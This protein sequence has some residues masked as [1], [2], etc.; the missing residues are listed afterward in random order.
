MASVLLSK[1]LL[2][3]D[4]KHLASKHHGGHPARYTTSAD[5]DAAVHDFTGFGHLGAF[6]CNDSCCRHLGG[7]GMFHGFCGLSFAYL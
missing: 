6:L 5:H 4:K 1:R 3:P 7:E 2:Q